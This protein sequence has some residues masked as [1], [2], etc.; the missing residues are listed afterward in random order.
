MMSAALDAALAACSPPAQ[1]QSE[2]TPTTPPPTVVA[3]NSVTPDASKQVA[4]QDELATAAAASEL[5]GGR[6]APGLYDLTTARRVGAATGWSGT[7]A[8]ALNVSESTGG[9]VTFNWAGAAPGG[10]SDTWTADFTDTPRVRLTYTCGRVG[11]VDAD[12][13]AAASRLELRL[14]DG[15]NGALHLV[16]AKRS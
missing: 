6:I 4:V 5:R 14:P 11:S 10:A 13:S 3:C 12:F 16:F 9:G 1:Q 2:Q 7:R 15:A 8:V